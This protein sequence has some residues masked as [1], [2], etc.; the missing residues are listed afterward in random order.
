MAYVSLGAH[1]AYLAHIVSRVSSM[2]N[3]DIYKSPMAPLWDYCAQ[4]L[5]I[6]GIDLVLLLLLLIFCDTL[7]SYSLILIRTITATDTPVGRNNTGSQSL[8]RG[9][10]EAQ[11]PTSKPK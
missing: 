8:P 9:G 2:S 3:L 4:N 10:A 11:S 1:L 6:C 7:L 5:V